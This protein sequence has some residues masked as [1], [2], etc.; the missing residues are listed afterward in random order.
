MRSRKFVG[1]KC[2]RRS[3]RKQSFCFRRRANNRSVIEDTMVF[4]PRRGVQHVLRVG[5]K[6]SFSG[7]SF[8]PKTDRRPCFPTG[9]ARHLPRHPPPADRR[10][11]RVRRPENVCRLRATDN[12]PPFPTLYVLWRSRWSQ[13]NNRKTSSSSS[14]SSSCSRRERA[15]F[16]LSLSLSLSRSPAPDPIKT[17]VCCWRGSDGSPGV[18][19]RFNSTALSYNTYYFFRPCTTSFGSIDIYIYTRTHARIYLYIFLFGVFVKVIF[20]FLSRVVRTRRRRTK[21]PL[22]NTPSRPRHPTAGEEARFSHKTRPAKP[23]S[24]L[25][26]VLRVRAPASVPRASV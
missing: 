26:G 21:T 24:T 20:F 11:Y 9:L 25:L 8:R 17:G 16:S 19:A 10:S 4:R 1:H 13:C 15:C 18:R 22:N 3:R 6:P 14:S 7:H 12:R 23:V 2:M 5:R